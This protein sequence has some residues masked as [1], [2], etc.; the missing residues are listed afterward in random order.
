MHW[1]AEGSFAGALLAPRRWGFKP[2]QQWRVACR[3]WAHR[4]RLA[5]HKIVDRQ[6]SATKRSNLARGFAHG[7]GGW[8]WL[9]PRAAGC[10]SAQVLIGLKR[11]AVWGLVSA[12]WPHEHPE[13]CAS[14]LLQWPVVYGLGSWVSGWERA[15]AGLCGVRSGDSHAAWRV[16]WWRPG[17]GMAAWAHPVRAHQSPNRLPRRATAGRSLRNEAQG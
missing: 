5:R 3:A 15:M 8:W 2:T 14:R 6:Q 16:V 10:E 12:A 4:W 17:L 13:A 11:A 1:G 9:W 7:L